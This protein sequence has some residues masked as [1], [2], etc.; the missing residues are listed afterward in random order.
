MHAAAA[1]IMTA[2]SQ[3]K[4][5]SHVGFTR[6]PITVASVVRSTINTI[7]G[8]ARTPLATADQKSIL[9]AGTPA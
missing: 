9:T 5:R 2:A 6:E 7:S 4:K 8:G 3:P 1:V